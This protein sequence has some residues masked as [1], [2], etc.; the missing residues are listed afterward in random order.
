M[1]LFDQIARD[2][3]MYTQAATDRELQEQRRRE[4]KTARATQDFYKGIEPVFKTA[5]DQALQPAQIGMQQKGMEAQQETLEKLS[6]Q[7]EANNFTADIAGQTGIPEYVNW[8]RSFKDA[9]GRSDKNALNLLSAE[10][11]KLPKLNQLM[12][13]VKERQRQEEL[14]MRYAPSWLKAMS[15]R[16]RAAAPSGMSDK[17]YNAALK[18][19]QQYLSST[20]KEWGDKLKQLNQ[21]TTKEATAQLALQAIPGN[22]NRNDINNTQ[23][24]VS[25][26]LQAAQAKHNEQTVKTMLSNAKDRYK[27]LIEKTQKIADPAQ[28]K[29]EAERILTELSGEAIRGGKENETVKQKFGRLIVL[30]AMGSS[31]IIATPKNTSFFNYTLPNAMANIAAEQMSSA[32]KANLDDYIK[33]EYDKIYKDVFNAV[34]GRGKISAFF[35]ATPT[36]ETREASLPGPYEAGINENMIRHFYSLSDADRVKILRYIGAT[37]GKGFNKET[38]AYVRPRNKYQESIYKRMEQYKD[39]LVRKAAKVIPSFGAQL[40]GAFVADIPRTIGDVKN[41]VKKLREVAGPGEV[42]E[43]PY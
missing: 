5:M 29:L 33:R 10:R 20:L 11:E 18:R 8:A 21:F 17:D 16:G 3:F 40:S 39:P 42:P 31:G 24:F 27:E 7:M 34:K 35:S 6:G 41:I 12:Q 15:G 2:T 36:P 14:Q 28:R 37:G 1:G 32:E 9:M 19:E 30:N 43:G 4:D 25:A 23:A 13:L 26:L 22:L 38:W